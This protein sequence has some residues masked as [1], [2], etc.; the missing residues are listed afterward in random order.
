MKNHLTRLPALATLV[1]LLVC[2]V[3]V[4]M[5][6]RSQKKEKD[7]LIKEKIE[8]ARM[9]LEIAIGKKRN[10]PGK[11]KV[12]LKEVTDFEWDRVYIFTPYTPLKEIDEALGF[13]WMQARKF[14]LERRD[15]INLLVFTASGEVVG[16]LKY[17]RH[18]GDF[19]GLKNPE[20]YS[21]AEATFNVET[22]GSDGE[23]G[24]WLVLRK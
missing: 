4:E 21:A 19:S 3:G 17:P 8:K 9:G 2:G 5:S 1:L 15:D 12:S 11:V 6:A 23:G 18:Y 14:Q 13:Q 24:A 20:G 7:A 16:Y 22:K 10:T